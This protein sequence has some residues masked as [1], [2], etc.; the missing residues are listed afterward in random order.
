M[1]KPIS[2]KTEFCSHSNSV[3]C[4]HDLKKKTWA[5]IVF[6]TKCQPYTPHSLLHS[7]KL[8]HSNL[9]D[10]G[11][12]LHQR[13]YTDCMYHYFF[14]VIRSMDFLHSTSAW[15]RLASWKN[16]SQL[17]TILSKDYRLCQE[18]N[19]AEVEKVH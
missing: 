8:I 18:V 4:L 15:S 12:Y 16:I 19:T 11:T 7:T 10:A 5:A 17:H 6:S 9:K 2:T 13:P 3:L 14:M 1:E